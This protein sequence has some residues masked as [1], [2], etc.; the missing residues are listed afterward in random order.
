[1][2]YLPDDILVLYVFKDGG[3][4]VEVPPIALPHVNI[5]LSFSN[6][7]PLH[8]QAELTCRIT[9]INDDLPKV[10]AGV[11]WRTSGFQLISGNEFWEGNLV[12]GTPV[13]IKLIVEPTVV[14][15]LELMGYVNA[16][17]ENQ[18]L[19]TYVTAT[20]LYVQVTEDSATLLKEP[21]PSNALSPPSSR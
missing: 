9:A 21:P 5:E 16:F 15:T 11:N 3:D 13:E 2:K 18:E 6:L 1:M 17:D 10:E 14:G 20:S 4:T 12:R 7:S 19:Y 8:R